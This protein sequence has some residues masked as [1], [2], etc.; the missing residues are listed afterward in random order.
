MFG[1]RLPENFNRP[2]SSVSVTDFWRRWHMSLSRW[3][4][5]YL[6]I[7]LGGN[8]GSTAPTYRN[9]FIVFV[10]TGFWHGATW[11]FLVWGLYHGSWLAIER[12]TGLGAGWPR[13]GW[14]SHAGR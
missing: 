9:L 8:R 6:Y 7:P 2:Y 3:F 10:A 13:T 5:D 12:A 11:T 4:R 14:W 1:F